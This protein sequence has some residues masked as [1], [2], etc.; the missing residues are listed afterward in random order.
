MVKRL[1]RGMDECFINLP[2]EVT[3]AIAAEKVLLV[4]SKRLRPAFRTGRIMSR[5]L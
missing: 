4:A 2:M 5:K 1:M 3:K